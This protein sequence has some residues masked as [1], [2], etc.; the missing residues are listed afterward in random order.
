MADAR[1]A[2]AI[3]LED[4]GR[5]E[6]ALAQY[7]ELLGEQ[8]TYA[9]AWHNHG[10]LLARLGRLSAAEQSHRS[11]LQQVPDDPRAHSNL[12]DVLLA[13]DRPGEALDALDWIVARYG[14]D[15]PALVRR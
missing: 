7:R 10:L 2:R 5:V 8:P 1:F 14:R 11:Y 3:A 12:A 13:L 4:A 6:E 15:V 9:D